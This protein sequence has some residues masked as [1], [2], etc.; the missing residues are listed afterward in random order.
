MAFILS[1]T[2]NGQEFPVI[3]R[4]VDRDMGSLIFDP[5]ITFWIHNPGPNTVKIKQIK[6]MSSPYENVYV[7]PEYNVINRDLSPFTA[8]RF[9]LSFRKYG[10]SEFT[11][12]IK[13]DDDEY[14]YRFRGVFVQY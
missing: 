12:V 4:D 6:V 13:T 1:A 5:D 3:P 11:L 14:Y 10:Y 9:V 2:V 8:T 7:N